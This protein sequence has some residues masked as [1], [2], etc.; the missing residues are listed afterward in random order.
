MI[1]RISTEGQYEIGDDDVDELNKL[2]NQAVA[3]CDSSDEQSFHATYQKLLDFARAVHFDDEVQ[4]LERRL[5]RA[6]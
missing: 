2:D 3:A 6:A 1:V 4:W 5:S